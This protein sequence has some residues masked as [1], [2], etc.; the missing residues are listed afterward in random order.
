MSGRADD[1]IRIVRLD[2][3]LRIRNHLGATPEQL[4]RIIPGYDPDVENLAAGGMSGVD[5]VTIMP[6]PDII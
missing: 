2:D 1:P 5:R 4:Y 3:G 6:E